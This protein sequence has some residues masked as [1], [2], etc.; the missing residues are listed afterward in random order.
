MNIFDVQALFNHV[1]GRKSFES[2]YQ[3]IAGDVNLDGSLT[4]QDVDVLLA[5]IGGERQHI[6]PEERWI[7]V[8]S[9]F[10]FDQSLD[11]LQQLFPQ[12]IMIRAHQLETDLDF[13]AIC[14]G[15]IVDKGNGGQSSKKALDEVE[16]GLRSAI[17]IQ[18]LSV[19]FSPNPFA[20]KTIMRISDHELSYQL[21]IFN[22]SG[23]MIL[24]KKNLRGNLEITELQNSGLY[25]YN[26]MVGEKTIQGRII[27]F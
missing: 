23:Q 20:E 6:N 26:L 12:E 13:T 14:L 15:D 16:V 21:K 2:P 5:Y 18:K 27:K 1:V 19:E 17:D 8:D 7:F 4:M 22:S 24:D 3:Y 10:E 9:D 11:P 25:I